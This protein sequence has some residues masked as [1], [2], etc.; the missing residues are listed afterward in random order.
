MEFLVVGGFT[1]VLL[2]IAW[3]LE[4]AFGVETSVY[5]V[6]FVFFY[7]AWVINDPHF[8]VTYLLFY[9]DVKRRAFGDVFT[10]VQ[11][12]RYWLAGFV[13]PVAL[14]GWAAVALWRGAP[15]VLG[16]MVELM[17]MLVGWHYVK[18]GFGVFS[19]LSARRGIRLSDL[20]RHAFL[21]HCFTGW[22]F[23]WARPAAP[24]VQVE[25]EG[26]V[27]RALPHPALLANVTGIL[28]A[29]S[30]VLLVV[31]LVR[32]W[33]TE[34]KLPPLAALTGLLASVWAWS[35]FSN[36]D[37]LLAYAIPALH[38]IQY[39]FFVWLLS[40]NKARANEGPPSFG[41]PVGLSVGLVALSALGLGWVL[42]HGGPTLL[43]TAMPKRGEAFGPTPYLAAMF[44][45]VNIHHYFMDFVIWRRENPET[46]FLGA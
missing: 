42:F 23:A 17:Y 40:R 28:F 15:P 27:Y 31:V 46:R 22:A 26:L 18:Q 39:L 24:A 29:A 41:R 16:A 19:V 14:F 12:A 25:E 36:A 45:F 21:A 2:P 33:R 13:V 4:R 38:S 43:D 20:E 8:S 5:P 30:T 44:T 6:S 3:A 32:K 10:P 34:R 37:P 1:L 9:K 35:V 7:A 11:R